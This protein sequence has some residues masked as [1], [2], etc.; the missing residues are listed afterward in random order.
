MFSLFLPPAVLTMRCVLWRQTERCHGE[1]ALAGQVQRHPAGG[2]YLQPRRR[3]QQFADQWCRFNDLLEVV[4]QQQELLFAQ[5]V[6]QT[7]EQ[8]AA[9]TL[10]DAERLRDRGG[11]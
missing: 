4:Q 10:L 11:N 8:R 3:C 7:V 9:R 1:F 2:Q 6:F 5:P